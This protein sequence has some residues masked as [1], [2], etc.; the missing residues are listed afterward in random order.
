MSKSLNASD[1]KEET[2][3]ESFEAFVKKALT[4]KKP[5]KNKENG[6]RKSND[7]RK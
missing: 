7:D 6:K 3:Q 2:T 5:K 1:K 4:T